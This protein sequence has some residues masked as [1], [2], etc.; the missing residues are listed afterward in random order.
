MRNKDLGFLIPFLFVAGGL[1]VLALMWMGAAYSARKRS[2]ALQQIAEQLGFAF[3]RQASLNVLAMCPK[4]TLFTTGRSQTLFNLMTG[5]TDTTE[6]MVFDWQYVTGSGKST[7]THTS[8]VAAIQSKELQLPGF[9]CR[10]ES[11]FD[12]I[13]LTFDGKDI[14][15]PD[16]PV[17]SKKFHL[18]GVLERRIRELFDADVC[19]FFTQLERPYAEGQGEWLIFCYQGKKQ[20]PDKV[21]DVF[22]QAFQLHLLLKREPGQSESLKSRA[23]DEGRNEMSAETEREF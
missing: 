6:V 11:V 17:F 8:T 5:A 23:S 9:L 14:D 19:D 18:H 22:T 10:P 13:G 16:Q 20:V 15:F 2:E 1:A 12:W 7:Q 4:F 3:Y 21:R